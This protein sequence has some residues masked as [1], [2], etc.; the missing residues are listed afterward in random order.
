MQ[1]VFFNPG[2]FIRFLFYIMFLAAE[3]KVTEVAQVIHK[4]I[5]KVAE[6]TEFTYPVWMPAGRR[7][8][9]AGTRTAPRCR[10]HTLASHSAAWGQVRGIRAAYGYSGRSQWGLG[11]GHRGQGAVQ[12]L[13]Q[14]T[15]GPGAGRLSEDLSVRV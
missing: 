2:A 14:F 1:S 11:A 12:I 8:Q 6:V 10:P 15:A 9:N 7:S 4:V 3:I 13:W 5:H